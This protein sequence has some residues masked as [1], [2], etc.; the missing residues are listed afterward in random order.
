MKLRIFDYESDEYL[1]DT[2]RI[3]HLVDRAGNVWRH[4]IS[5]VFGG[6]DELHFTSSS[7]QPLDCRRSIHVSFGVINNHTQ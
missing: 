7:R 4:A 3:T 5:N 1:E 6:D 2:D